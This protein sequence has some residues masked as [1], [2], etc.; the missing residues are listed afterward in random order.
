MTATFIGRVR[1][2]S[3]LAHEFRRVRELGESRVTMVQGRRQVG[4]S[5]LVEH[6]A[7]ST[8]RPYAILSGVKDTAESIQAARAVES[9][10]ASRRP[11]VNAAALSP[12][13]FIASWT[14][15]A[16]RLGTAVGDEPSVLVWDE[17][18]WAVESSPGLDGLLKA[19]LDGVLR[20]SPLLVILVG[21]DQSLMEQLITYDRPL[22]GKISRQIVLHPFDPADVADALGPTRSAMDA[23]DARLVTGGFPA[24]VAEAASHR[25]VAGFVRHSLSSPSSPLVTSARIRL[26]AEMPDSVNANVVLTSIGANEI[27]ES[28]FSQIVSVLGGGGTAQTAVSRA[29][30]QLVATRILAVDQPAGAPHSRLRRYRIDD[31]YLRFWF[32]FVEPGLRSIDVGRSD[33][34]TAAFDRGWTSWRGRAVEPLVRASLLRHCALLPEPYVATV[35]I[36][37]WWDR[38]GQY[39]FDLVG[40]AG[41][42]HPTFVGSVKWRTTKAFS[43]SEA[44]DVI[45]A[46]SI[47]PGAASAPVIAVCPAGVDPR[48]PV[49]QVVGPSELVGAWRLAP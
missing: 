2:L 34:V 20:Q 35:D 31:S 33:L 5:R 42:R 7:E 41:D 49:D 27:G 30:D 21:S 24:L 48:A 10:H 19:L 39:E 12:L 45:E 11:L 37:G 15:I 46:R 47:I 18:P 44:A 23:F 26:A 1:E 32:R 4:K 9:I 3:D 38:R 25:T 22:Y 6:F 14:T 8:G 29:T 17:F 40:V 43:R 28:S 13:E 16:S 36:G